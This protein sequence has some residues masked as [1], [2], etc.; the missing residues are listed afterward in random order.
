M[1]NDPNLHII[2]HAI[3]EDRLGKMR[4]KDTSPA[5]FRRYMHEISV[6]LGMEATRALPANIQNVETPL[7]TTKVNLLDPQK[8]PLIIPILRAGLGLSEG[9]QQILPEADTGHIG[10]YRDEETHMPVEYLVKLPENL[11]RPILICDPMLATGHSMEKTIDILLEKGASE[12]SIIMITLLCAPE[13]IEVIRKRFP[14]MPI[15]TA[16]L[17]SHLNENAYIVPGLGDAGD[18]IFGTV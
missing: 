1:S 15:Y 7:T 4:C 5:L 14:N 10:L 11:D 13:G 17:D 9:V 16:A 3:I 8:N 12:A 2:P 18:R 6:I